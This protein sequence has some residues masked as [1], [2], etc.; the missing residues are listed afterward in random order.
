MAPPFKLNIK[1]IFSMLG[2][3]SSVC[4]YVYL[5]NVKDEGLQW[6]SK[7]LTPEILTK[8]LLHL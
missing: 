6:V 3:Y 2:K 5:Y 4:V 1:H 7:S 8:S